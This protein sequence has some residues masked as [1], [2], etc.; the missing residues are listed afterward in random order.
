[1]KFAYP[2]QVA[3]HHALRVKVVQAVDDVQELRADIE[4]TREISMEKSA[5]SLTNGRRLNWTSILRKSK[6]FPFGIHLDTRHSG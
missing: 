5:L 1:M 3:V 4:V 2:F 6:T